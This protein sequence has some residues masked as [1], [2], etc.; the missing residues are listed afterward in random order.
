MALYLGTQPPG[1]RRL[2]RHADE[3]DDLGIYLDELI[4]QKNITALNNFSADDVSYPLQDLLYRTTGL[5][6]DS[7]VIREAYDCDAYGNTLIFRNTGSP[8]AAITFTDSDTQVDYPTCEF[9]FTGQRWD[10]ESQVYHYKARFYVPKLGRF[11]QRDLIEFSDGR[12]IYRYVHN[13]PAKY[14]D[15]DGR[16]RLDSPCSRS[17]SCLI[18][19][20]NNAIKVLHAPA[21][22]GAGNTLIG[23]DCL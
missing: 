18:R 8:P 21:E 22:A 23:F 11:G 4:Q 7:G 9:I 10:A 16:I 20:R 12:Q 1:W 3:A 19:R 15:S 14:L 13:N 5:S 6:D 2:H 17:A